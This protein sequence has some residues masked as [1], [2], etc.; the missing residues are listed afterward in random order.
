MRRR[1]FIA[2]LSGAAAA[3]P[4]AARAQQERMRRIGMMMNAAQTDALAQTYVTA[5]S[6][7]LRSL[8]WGD[9][10]LQI[11]IRWN[12]GSAE[13]ARRYANE[14]VALAPDAI[15]SA[16]TNN[17]NELQRLSP[18]IPIVFLDV[19]DPVAQG[20]VLN[21]AHPGGNITGFSFFEVQTAGKWLDLLKQTAPAVA[22]V[23]VIYNPDTSPPSRLYSNALKG[24]AASFGVEVIESLVHSTADIE[25]AIERLAREPGGALI[26]TPDQ[27]IHVH[28]EL[29]VKLAARYRLPAI[30]A[31]AGFAEVGG[32]MSYYPAEME[33]FRQAA[34]YID[35]I[36]KG[37]K[38]GDLP[39][40]APT[41]F[42]LI[43]NLKTAKALGLTVPLGLLAGADAVIE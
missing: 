33:Q 13:M 21:Q 34:S 36:L 1:E 11:E 32:L 28:R 12:D 24:A 37:A 3:W 41:R 19:A 40:Q 5:F 20:F 9:S 2:L 35:R 14:L 6:Q 23:A 30:Y 43:V 27:F 4:L 16:S 29:V 39:V 10:Q 15:L 18:T 7:A 42:E 26:F 17:L 31:R 22:R 8:G 25:P 38:P